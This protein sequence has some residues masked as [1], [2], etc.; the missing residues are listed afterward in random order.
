LI[1]ALPYF[2]YLRSLP[3]IET[4]QVPTT[5]KP[6]I[7]RPLASALGVFQAKT[8]AILCLVFPLFLFGLWMIYS[9]LARH[10]EETYSLS[11]AQ[12]GWIS[13]V[14]LQGATI[15]GLFTGGYLA[16]FSRKAVR[17]G[18]MIVLLASLLLCSPLLIAIGET[19]QLII[20]K[21]ILV[22]Y[23]FFS[24]WMIG[25][26]FPAAFEVVGSNQRGFAVGIL[27]LFGAALS[28]FA[29]L[30]VGTW[31]Q[32]LGFPGML[33]Y[34]SLAYGIAAILLLIAIVF[35]LPGDLE[36]NAETNTDR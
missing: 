25:N 19:E 6:Q 7:D 14:Y 11:T 35:T 21:W 33:R 1:Y 5:E 24:G 10:I 27:N 3:N 20:L 18:R 32:T 23:G 26:I 4:E 8:Y 36:R 16:D 28:G 9:W 29:P 13:T 34:A 30:L 12:A 17:T 15:V 31:K 22:G 2:W